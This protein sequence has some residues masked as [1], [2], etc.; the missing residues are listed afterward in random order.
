[1]RGMLFWIALAVMCCSYS[2]LGLDARTVAPGSERT[3]APLPAGDEFPPVPILRDPFAGAA[4]EEAL[5][6]TSAAGAGAPIVPNIDIANAPLGSS[7]IVVR[8]T[9]VGSDPVAYIDDGT[10]EQLARIGDVVAGR[11]VAA[12]DLQ[13]ITFDDGT[14]AD[15]T[16]SAP[17]D[18][19]PS[20]QPHPAA[21]GALFEHRARHT[22][23]AQPVAPATR[24]A[25]TPNPTPAP[26][27]TVDPRGLPP[28]ANPTPD[29]L[30]PTPLPY[31]FPYAPP[32]RTEGP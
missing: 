22:T 24:P 21:A 27:R 23:P 13:G 32:R 17:A 4:N 1:M 30:G 19:P 11:N 10:G 28:G 18:L 12:I 15:L 26:L 20:P 31:A 2:K 16:A 5:P 14:R 6:A 9:I 8:A 25:S 3:A 29:A 7:R